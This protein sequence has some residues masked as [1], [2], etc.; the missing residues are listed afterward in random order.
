M[1]HR[2]QHRAFTVSTIK[3][4]NMF[5]RRRNV[6][7]ESWIQG[8]NATRRGFI[9]DGSKDVDILLVPYLDI[10]LFSYHLK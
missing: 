10:L 7:P 4:L 2:V 3:V 6:K 1:L 9:L 5:I 8:G